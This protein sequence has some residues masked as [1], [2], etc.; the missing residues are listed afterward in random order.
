MYD[1]LRGLRVVEASAFVA[2]PSCALYLAQLGAEVVRID[3][4]GGGPDFHRW[5]LDARS[6][7]SL[8]WEGLNKSKKSVA[9]DLTRPEGREIAMRIATA[10]GENAGLFVTNY[11]VDG[12]FS[13]DALRQLRHDLICVRIMGWPDGRPAVDY[14]INAAVG[15][16]AMTGPANDSRPVNHVLPAWDLLAGAYAAFTLL[17]AERARRQDGRGREIRIP[18]SDLAIA[19]LGHLGQIG[20]VQ[21]CGQDR[22]RMGNDLYGAFGRDFE[23]LDGKRLM[24]VAITAR[25]WSGLLAALGLQARISELESELGVRF[26]RDEGIRFTHRRRL[27]PLIE[28]AIAGRTADDLAAVFE[29]R[30]VC[31]APYQTLQQAVSTDR[32]F[33]AANPVLSLID[34]PS[35]QRYLTPGAAASLPS[36]PRRAPAAAHRLGQD[37]DE[38]LVELLDL[39]PG[40][41][42]RLHDLGLAG[43]S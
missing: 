6:G 25:Q 42:G 22:A 19:S 35:G 32:Y 37:T 2:A 23:T 40:E 20:E 26:D 29:A 4:I 36:E 5:P 13:Y 34:H 9:L 41:I 16:P 43:G 39:S 1:L 11:P 17:A 15:V 30:S 18:L 24:V 33:S 3:Q 27:V 7:A 31:W 38:V 28:S 14:T 21:T 12:Y 8:Y 10:P